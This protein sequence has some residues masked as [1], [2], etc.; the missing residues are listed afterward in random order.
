MNDILIKTRFLLPT[1]PRAEKLVAKYL[2]DNPDSI[3]NITLLIL[4]QETG[5]SDT[6][7][8]RFCRRLGYDGFSSFKQ[9][10]MEAAVDENKTITQEIY[11]EDSMI[12]ILNKVF[13]HN[14]ETLNNTLALVSEDYSKALEALL[15]AKSVHFFGVGDAY[16]VANLAYMKFSRLGYGGSAHSDVTLQLITASLLSENDVALAI[17]YSGASDNIVKAMKVA[18]DAGATTICITQMNKSPL[19]KYTDI[20]LFISTSDLTVGKDIVSRRVADQAI[21]EALYLGVLTKTERDGASFI[22]KTQKA[23]DLNKI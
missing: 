9:S 10:F 23:I 20:N 11:S 13:K 2:L 16:I 12:D 19:L 15:K 21:I 17:S 18:K 7:I 5:S 8:I 6:S 1:L 14:I 22:K 4:A 3:R